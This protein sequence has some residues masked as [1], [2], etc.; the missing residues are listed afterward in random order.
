MTIAES[1][2]AYHVEATTHVL[3][4]AV[5]VTSPTATGPGADT[6]ATS[7]SLDSQKITVP[8]RVPAESVTLAKSFTVS[9]TAIATLSGSTVT[10]EP[11][12]AVG[13]GGKRPVPSLPPSQPTRTSPHGIT[14]P[15]AFVQPATP[16][17]TTPTA[18][19]TSKGRRGIVSS[20]R[21]LGANVRYRVKLTIANQER[22]KRWFRGER[23]AG[24]RSSIHGGSASAVV[25]RTPLAQR[26]RLRSG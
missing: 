14:G 20:N 2:C 16:T 18:R 8:Q 17:R 19:A 10:F 24:G 11:G 7:V 21:L 13:A 12:G 5:P 22:L 15:T 1:G 3:P 25:S 23:R 4:P 26:T 6:V 9:P